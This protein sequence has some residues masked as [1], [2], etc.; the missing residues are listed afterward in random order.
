MGLTQVWKHFDL[1]DPTDKIACPCCGILHADE[2][3]YRHMALLDRMREELGFPIIIKSGQRCEAHNETV[4][5]VKRSQHVLSFATD[6]R[7]GDHSRTKLKKMY[8]KAKEL[9]FTGI[10]LGNTFLHVDLRDTP[11]EWRY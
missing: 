8:K 9:G 4:G 7:P 10:G 11:A 1:D 6:I 2:R 5:G 3:F